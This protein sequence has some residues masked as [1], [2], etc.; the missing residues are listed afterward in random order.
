MAAYVGLLRAVNVGGTGKLPMIDLRALAE[1]AGFTQVQT[2][3]AS[4]NLVFDYKGTG[5]QA[6]AILQDR[7]ADYAGKPVGV[8]IR[9]AVEMA[10]IIADNPFAE[11]PPNKVVTIFLD[12]Q[13]AP[14]ALEQAV[15]GNGEEMALGVR[16]IYVHYV[17]GQ[18][19]S[20]LRIP[21]AAS[22]TARNMNTVSKLAGMIG[23]M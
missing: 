3:I 4:G 6:Q 22:G 13:P 23:E 5:A 2:Y 20:K 16:E 9:T 8:M 1:A 19:V 17:R 21:Q 15:G 11:A 10:Q 7:L 12:A 18:G 14:D